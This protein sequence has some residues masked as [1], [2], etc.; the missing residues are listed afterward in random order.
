MGSDLTQSSGELGPTADIF[1]IRVGS[2]LALENE[3]LAVATLQERSQAAI[4]MF[5]RIGEVIRESPIV[6]SEPELVEPTSVRWMGIW[7]G[8][9]DRARVAV[10]LNTAIKFS[11]HWPGKN[12]QTSH[13]YGST[14]VE[15]FRI[16]YD[17]SLF[18][19]TVKCDGPIEGP[20]SFGF[21][22]EGFRILEE[23]LGGRDD[24]ELARL[25]P[26]PMFLVFYVVFADEPQQFLLGRDLNPDERLLVLAKSSV[27]QEEYLD[28][29]SFRLRESCSVHYEALA[30]RL[31]F[32]IIPAR[33]TSPL[34]KLP[35]RSIL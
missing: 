14:Y 17:G 33:S 30:E 15:T 19:T 4:D 16:H 28:F 6:V 21:G 24:L 2:L 27:D 35:Q 25:G 13:Y 20:Y 10:R 11:A 34:N 26:T 3:K 29:V 9:L 23:I 22:R 1:A 32:C 12:Q 7:P 31:D 8:N 18:T 5:M